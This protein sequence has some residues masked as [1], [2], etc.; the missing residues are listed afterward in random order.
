MSDKLIAGAG[1]TDVTPELGVRL[2]G[3]GRKERPTENILDPLHSTALYLT[4]GDVRAMF[5]NLDWIC[6]DEE[7]TATIRNGVEA[8][9]GISAENII[10]DA[11]HSHST[12]NTLAAW[13]WGDKEREYIASKIPA[14]IE[15]AKTAVD[16]AR[17][18]KVGIQTTQ[19]DVGVNRRGITESHGFSFLG[20]ERGMYDPTMTVIRLVSDDAPICDVI[21]YGA[22]GTAMGVTNDV[23]RDWPGV[24]KDRIESQTK[25]PIVFVQ[26]PIG[27][28]GPRTNK[29]VKGGFSSGTGDGRIAVVEVGLRGAGDAIR[30]RQAVRDWRD[31]MVV[32]VISEDITLPFAPLPSRE[33]AEKELAASEPKKDEWG[34]GMA[35]YKYWRSVVDEYESGDIKSSRPF[36]QTIIRLG[37]V[38]IIPFPGELFSGISLRLRRSSP[39]T[40]TLCASVANGSLGYLPTR[41]A[42]HRGGYE[43]WVGRAYGPY[44]L[45]DDIDDRLVEQNL[46]LLRK[47]AER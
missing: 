33:E 41:E 38:A 11:M 2:G 19:S 44:L 24:M 39:F 3:Y 46:A 30:A 5:I 29:I 6:V 14:I 26:G 9:T 7:D 37:P 13:G 22:H 20:D 15:S 32:D 40:H 18:A 25:V 16:S 42:R 17:P 31:D 10:V 8:E 34:S 28:V 43:T 21:H 23:S 47:L 36:R 27:D 12:P 4:R 45:A 1:R 35:N